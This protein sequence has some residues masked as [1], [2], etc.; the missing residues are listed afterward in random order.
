[1]KDKDIAKILNWHRDNNHWE[2]SES[3]D[4]TDTL[5]ALKALFREQIGE[6]EIQMNKEP[7]LINFPGLK[8]G[9]ISEDMTKRNNLRS[10]QRAKLRKE[11]E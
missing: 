2:D 1:M 5:I 4:M 10:E 3:Y 9:Y 8:V 7:D 6:D 11:I